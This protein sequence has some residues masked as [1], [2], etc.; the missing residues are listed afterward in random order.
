MLT[1]IVLSAH[2]LKDVN[3]LHRRLSDLLNLL[4]SHL[5]RWGDVNDL[6]RVLLRC[7]FV[8]TATHHTAH[9]PED[10]ETQQ[11]CYLQL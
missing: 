5:V 7:P 8:D 9:S 2:F 4:R 1:D 11:P 3:F 10:E 6:H